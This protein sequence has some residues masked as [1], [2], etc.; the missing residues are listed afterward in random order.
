MNLLIWSDFNVESDI[1]LF[2]HTILEMIFLETREK[3]W[4]QPVIKDAF[5]HPV[6]PVVR[7]CQY[8]N[9]ECITP[10]HTTHH[11]GPLPPPLAGPQLRTD[12]RSC[13]LSGKQP[14]KVCRLPNITRTI[15]CS[16]LTEKSEWL[17]FSIH[18]SKVAVF[19][20][21]PYLI[22]WL[23]IFINKKIFILI[24]VATQTLCNVLLCIHFLVWTL[25]FFY[26]ISGTNTHY[27]P[28]IYLKQD[29]ARNRITTLE[30]DFNWEGR[31][32]T[33][34]VRSVTMVAACPTQ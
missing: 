20:I 21:F 32:N 4:Q 2:T 5:E 17:K 13:G 28:F 10:H 23:Q 11:R 34:I 26:I 3:L 27:F 14:G 22:C 7:P 25:L 12:G 6:G 33:I 18:W 16:L 8:I 31:T 15:L 29:S 1:I 30:I 19:H 24:D 9:D